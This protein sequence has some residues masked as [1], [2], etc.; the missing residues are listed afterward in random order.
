MPLIPGIIKLLE[1]TGFRLLILAILV[2]IVPAVELCSSILPPTA[3]N[4]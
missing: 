2:G 4:I 3:S 1:R